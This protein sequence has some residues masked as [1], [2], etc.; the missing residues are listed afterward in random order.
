[1]RSSANGIKLGTMTVGGYENIR[2]INNKIYDTYRSALT[3][4][5]PDGGYARNIVVDSLQAYN[6]GNAIFLRIGNRTHSNKIGTMDS[7][8]ISNLYVEIPEGKPDAGYEYEGPIEH[9]PRNISPASIIG[10]KG[11]PITHVTL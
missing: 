3:I 5:T 9:M 8:L 10:L 2:I 11:H 6:T 1:M 4:A 7:I